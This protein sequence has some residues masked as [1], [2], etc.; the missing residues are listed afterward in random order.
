M[1]A[2]KTTVLVAAAGDISRDSYGPGK[3]TKE[4]LK[5]LAEAASPHFNGGT[6]RSEQSNTDD[7][8]GV[9]VITPSS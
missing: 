8:N 7:N 1:G 6:E 3:L 2:R 5:A 4:E 9:D